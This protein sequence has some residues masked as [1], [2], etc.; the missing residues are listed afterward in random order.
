MPKNCSADVEKVIDYID[1]VLMRGSESEKRELKAKFGMEGVEHDDDFVDVL[2]LGPSSWQEDS[3]TSGYSA[4]F[5]WC[6]YVEVSSALD[7]NKDTS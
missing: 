1:D 7:I 5:Q 2:T 4:F 3:F 6:D